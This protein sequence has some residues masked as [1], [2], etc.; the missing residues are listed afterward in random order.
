MDMN[1]VGYI[2]WLQQLINDE[3]KKELNKLKYVKAYPAKVVLVGTN[4]ANVTLIGETEILTNLKNKTNQTLIVGDNVYLFS[5]T[6]NL[7]NSY[8]AVK[9]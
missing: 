4:T 8:I 2:S 5:P 9:F 7:T 6:N 1:D 3:V